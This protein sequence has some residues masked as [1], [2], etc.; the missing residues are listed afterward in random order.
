MKWIVV[1]FQLF[2]ITS[3]GFGQT[4]GDGNKTDS[5]GRKQGKWVKFHEDT[6]KKRYEGTFENNI[7]IGKFTYYY[8][9][10]EVS[11]VTVFIND[12]KTA[13]TR[14]YHLNGKVM[15]AGK[16]I[17]Q[18]KDSAW[19]SFNDRN[20]IISK[21]N[22]VDG[23]LN[24]EIVVYYPSDPAK[25]KVKRYE[26]TDY[27]NGLKHGKWIQFFSTGRVKAEGVYKDGNYDGRLKWYHSNGKV[28]IDG[29]YKHAVKNGYWKYY[30]VDGEFKR[31]VY[32]RDGH[33]IEGDVL[34]RHLARIKKAKA[35]QKTKLQ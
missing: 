7:P 25:G 32:Y 22:Y 11:A 17:D 21:E 3:M 4:Q 26:I 13:Y 1:V 15:A 33:V 18:K 31:K 5:K 10:G 6:E 2:L 23:K 12:H 20:E 27:L 28:E 35:E 30:E 14:M 16:Y 29:Y 19:L 34:E 24:G 9:T 8:L